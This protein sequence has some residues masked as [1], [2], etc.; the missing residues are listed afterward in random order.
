MITVYDQ[1]IYVASTDD[2]SWEQLFTNTFSLHFMACMINYLSCLR[3]VFRQQQHRQRYP[4][5]DLRIGR[6]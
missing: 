4:Y 6:S 2:H 3:K 1:N 5:Y